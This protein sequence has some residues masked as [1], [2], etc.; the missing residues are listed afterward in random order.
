MKL[1]IIIPVRN[2]EF[3]IKK[4]VDQLQSK[5]KIIPYEII[6]INDFSTDNT[7]KIIKDLIKTE[8]QINIYDNKKKGLGGAITEG[9][10]KA[11][12]EVI[13]IMMSDLSDSIDDLEKYYSTI[14][15]ENIDAVF[16]SRF[17]R[18][19][20]IV[21]YPKKKLILNRI[22]NIITKLL[23]ISDYNDFTNAF[24]IYKKNAL[25]KTLPLVSESFNIFL[26]LPLKIISRKMKYKI[27][28]ISWINRKEGTSKFD[29]KELR[30]KYLFTLIYCLLEKILLKK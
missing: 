15:D 13:C 19:S 3:L 7:A 21:D 14:K 5:L 25:L 9:I 16:G 12:G 10:N 26:E 6:F 23:F 11:T 29:I 18:G 4:I 20:R 27:I 30:A 24:K 1:S 8:T 22:F 17:I 2:E 28:P